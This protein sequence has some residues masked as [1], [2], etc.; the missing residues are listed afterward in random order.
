MGDMTGPDLAKLLYSW[1]MLE[2]HPEPELLADAKASFLAAAA[3]G[4]L[5]Q[6]NQQQEYAGQQQWAEL[7]VWQGPWMAAGLWGLAKLG[8]RCEGQVLVLLQ[9]HWQQLMCYWTPQQMADVASAIA[10]TAD[11]HIATAVTSGDL[12]AQQMSHLVEQQL[13]H[14]VLG[15]AGQMLSVLGQQEEGGT[16]PEVPLPWPESMLIQVQQ[17]LLSAS[18]P[19]AQRAAAAVSDIAA[20]GA[21]D[22]SSSSAKGPQGSGDVP[23][24]VVHN[25]P[26]LAWRML[27]ALA[28]VGVN[29]SE[30]EDQAVG[31]LVTMLSAATKVP[32]GGS[33]AV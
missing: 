18:T 19:A 13:A 14:M 11:E 21:A 1:A 3:G 31:N 6:Q 20:A 7:Q 24:M 29:V 5:Q 17:A 9:Q 8:E 25:M 4:G 32:G 2:W 28:A 33:M 26:H 12:E 27:Q 30:P 23:M 22:S 16:E 15:L 10:H